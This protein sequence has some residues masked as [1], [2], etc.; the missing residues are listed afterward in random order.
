MQHRTTPTSLPVSIPR[1]VSTRRARPAPRAARTIRSL[2]PGML[3]LLAGCGLGQKVQF[4]WSA[5]MRDP[6]DY[7]ALEAERAVRGAE[8]T[9][10]VAETPAASAAPYWT[11]Y[12][13][14]LGDGIYREQNLALDWD[15]A[16]PP[17]LWSVVVGPAYSSIV[18][19]HGLAITMEQRRER[20]MVVA[21]SLESGQVVWEHGWEARYSDA[22]SKEG[23]RATPA[24]AGE[25]VVTLGAKG[26]LRCLDLASGELRWRH[27]L[28]DPDGPNLE[29]GLA[30][31]PRIFEV[32]GEALVI[33][34]GHR[35]LFAFA[36]GSGEA[37]WRALDE[38]LAYVTPSR[39]EVLG[40][41]TLLVT[42]AERV[43]GLDP[44]SGAELWSFPWSV[45]GGLACT[46]P[47]V[48]APDRVLVSAGYGKGSQLVELGIDEAGATGTPEP[49][50]LWR[51]AHF[52]TRFNEPLWLAGQAYGLD[53]GR[54]MCLDLDTG[55][56]RW[57][58]GSY[59]YGQLLAVGDEA[60]I[61][62]DEEGAVHSL[63]LG[64]EGPLERGSF[65]GLEGGMTLNLPALAH[66][67]LLMRS[68]KQLACFDLRPPAPEG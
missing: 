26:E 24:L 23:P 59:G 12:R 58:G 52:K 44:D 65:Q 32:D 2:A 30:A 34:Q 62:V 64:P 22:L 3:V 50:S 48:V 56:P 9:P 66:G 57:R 33:L 7:D 28:M 11:Q 42:A 61:A 16:P 27:A 31:S 38:T 13:G 6:A 20:E 14:P 39:A 55:R 36:L 60:L 51:T 5:Y 54:L 53:E 68:E 67:R 15:A 46:Q 40:R 10:P 18:V 1:S 37:R 21:F 47:I 19:A 41:D 25:F 63:G 29:Y 8:G 17:R 43:V 45:L 35:S 49:R 4:G